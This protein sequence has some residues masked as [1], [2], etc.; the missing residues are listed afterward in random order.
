M[1]VCFIL[2]S[3]VWVAGV[4]A[5]DTWLTGLLRVSD[6]VTSEKPLVKAFRGFGCETLHYGNKSHCLVVVQG[7]S[8]RESEVYRTSSQ[9][10]RAERLTR[11]EPVSQRLSSTPGIRVECEGAPPIKLTPRK[12]YLS[13][14]ASHSTS[15]DGAKYREMPQYRLS[16]LLDEGKLKFVKES[17]FGSMKVKCSN[18]P[19]MWVKKMPKLISKPSLRE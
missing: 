14:A 18:M 9:A 7:D 10:I 4:A 12:C 2:V 17:T 1:K 11:Y 5:R 19:Y 8:V 15:E 6:A 16:S 3:T 13:A